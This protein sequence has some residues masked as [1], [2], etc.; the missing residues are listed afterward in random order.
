MTARKTNALL[1]LDNK[2]SMELYDLFDD[3]GEQLLGNLCIH[4]EVYA[5]NSQMYKVNQIIRFY[6]L[7]LQH[8]FHKHQN[9]G[10]CNHKGAIWKSLLQ[11]K[12]QTYSI[13]GIRF[14]WKLHQITQHD[15]NHVWH[16]DTIFI[17]HFALH[18]AIFKIIAIYHF[19]ID[20]NIKRTSCYK[21]HITPWHGW[22]FT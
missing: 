2:R 17:V 21:I 6:G 7:L 19:S 14:C 11:I 16:K 5:N 9:K 15:V 1:P 13:L 10:L 8:I 22:P 12:L 4:E 3:S 20:H 18:L